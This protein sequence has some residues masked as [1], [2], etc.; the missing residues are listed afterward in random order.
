MTKEERS[1]INE[2]R[3]ILT[4]IQVD[5]E[6]HNQRGIYIKDRIEKMP[7]GIHSDTITQAQTQLKFQWFVISAIAI[8][9]LGF[10]FK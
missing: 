5:L 10:I 3:N 1:S 9:L 6:K 4:Q 2:I 8:A 7:C